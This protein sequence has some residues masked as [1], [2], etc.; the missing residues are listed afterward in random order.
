MASPKETLLV[1]PFSEML[2]A[3]AQGNLVEITS[4]LLAAGASVSSCT[5]ANR[6]Q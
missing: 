2:T 3:E 6:C 1:Q 4:S 5:V